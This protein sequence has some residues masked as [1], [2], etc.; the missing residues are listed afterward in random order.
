VLV[1]R[2]EPLPQV[3][4]GLA[5]VAVMQMPLSPEGAV[6][7]EATQVL[8][9]VAATLVEVLLQV[10]AVVQVVVVQPIPLVSV[11]AAV[12]VWVSLVKDQA[13]LL[14][15]QVL[16]ALVARVELTALTAVFLTLVQ[17]RCEEA[18]RRVCLVVAVLVLLASK[19]LQPPAHPEQSASSGPV[20]LAP[21][22]RLTSE[23][24]KEKSCW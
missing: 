8:E 13:G 16:A 19:F 14:W 7:L 5:G 12:G 18:G 10:Q 20:Q 21:S 4:E 15:Q 2:V 23:H 17:I 3:Q 9:A 6:G 11:L 24:H 1:E 22:H